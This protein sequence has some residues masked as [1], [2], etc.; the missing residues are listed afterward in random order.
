M[1]R[2]GANIPASPEAE[3]VLHTRGVLVLP[4]FVADA[5]GVICA[6]VEHAGGTASQAFTVI[7]ERIRTNTDQMLDASAETGQPPPVVAQHLAQL[8]VK[9]AMNYRWLGG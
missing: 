6:A 7:E 8:R 2:E 4:D 9:V 3:E 5:G 1:G